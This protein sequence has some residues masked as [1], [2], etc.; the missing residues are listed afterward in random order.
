MSND[1]SLIYL[2]V[3]LCFKKFIFGILRPENAIYAHSSSGLIKSIF[4]DILL[5]GLVVSGNTTS[6]PI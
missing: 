4:L 3:S 6:F 5:L 2:L 1:E